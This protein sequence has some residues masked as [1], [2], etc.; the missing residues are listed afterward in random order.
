[1]ADADATELKTGTQDI[2]NKDGKFL[3]RFRPEESGHYEISFNAPL[4]DVRVYDEEGKKVGME[5]D[6]Y[7]IYT[8]WTRTL[9][10]TSA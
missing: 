9:P 4:S 3:L 7:A 2:Q 6:D 1:M 5:R 10:I 8:L